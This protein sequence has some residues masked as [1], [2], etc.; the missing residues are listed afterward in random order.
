MSECLWDGGAH[1]FRPFYSPEEQGYYDGCAKCGR[2]RE[3]SDRK[4]GDTE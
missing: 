4:V 3:E 1:E 2:T